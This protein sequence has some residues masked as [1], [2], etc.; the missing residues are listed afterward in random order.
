MIKKNI[1][2]AG[3]SREPVTR[4]FEPATPRYRL[5]LSSSTANLA[6]SVSFFY[7]RVLFYAL[8][9][10]LLAQSTVELRGDILKKKKSV[11]KAF[12]SFDASKDD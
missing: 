5:G 4:H 9:K 6:L 1:P 11:F 8:R 12:A 7:S 10:P 2:A 3:H